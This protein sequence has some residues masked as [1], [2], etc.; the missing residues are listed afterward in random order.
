MSL[1]KSGAGVLNLAGVNTH[2]P[3]QHRRRHAAIGQPLALGTGPVALSSPGVLDLAG[4]S[5]STSALSG[6]SGSTINSS[7][8]GAALDGEH[9]RRKHLDLLRR[10]RQRRRHRVLDKSG[11]GVLN[12]AGVNT[13]TGGTNIGGGTV[14]L[15]NSSAWATAGGPLLAPARARSGR[16]QL[17]HPGAL[18]GNSGSTINSSVAGA[19]RSRRTFPSQTPRPSPASSPTAAAPYLLLIKSGAGVLNL[20]GVNT[21]TG[22]TNIGGGTVQL[23]NSSGTGHRPG[24]PLLARRARSGRPQL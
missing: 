11:A 9:S 16:P 7:V 5:F 24:G 23:G 3:H 6:N 19:A 2:R 13:Y 1:I 21:Y 14:Q 20:A 4:L 18:S 8:A 10:H 12:L 17:W 15:G 22:G